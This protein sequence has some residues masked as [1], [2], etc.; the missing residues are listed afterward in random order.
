VFEMSFFLLVDETPSYA[1]LWLTSERFMVGFFFLFS[2]VD[3]G[4]SLCASGVME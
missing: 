1:P 4:V 3:V 2:V